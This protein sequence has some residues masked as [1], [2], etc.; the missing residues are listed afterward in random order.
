MTGGT[1]IYGNLHL[2][3]PPAR[4]E[5]VALA[6]SPKNFWKPSRTCE[7]GEVMTPLAS[8]LAPAV[9][10]DHVR[11]KNDKSPLSKPDPEPCMNAKPSIGAKHF[12]W[13]F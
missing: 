12:R 11:P 2:G 4:S 1:S 7:R 3:K 9:L 8:A 10:L 13:L 6:K 5:K